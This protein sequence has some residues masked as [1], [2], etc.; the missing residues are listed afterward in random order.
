MKGKLKRTVCIVLALCLILSLAPAVVLADGELR[1][2]YEVN[3]A[4]DL[5]TAINNAISYLNLDGE[6][7]DYAEVWIIGSL[8]LSQPITVGSDSLTI[9][10]GK[11]LRITS[12]GRHCINASVEVNVALFEVN[13]MDGMV[14]F[15]NLEL[16]CENTNG[17][18]IVN[19][20]VALMNMDIR[21]YSGTNHFGVNAAANT[22]DSR[23]FIKNV[24]IQSE[25]AQGA[26]ALVLNVQ[27]HTMNVDIYGGR[28]WRGDDI[29]Y[30]TRID[31]LANSGASIT[32]YGGQFGFDPTDMLDSKSK[33]EH[34][35]D[36]YFVY[37]NDDVVACIGGV[38]YFTN[39]QDAVNAAGTP[40]V[41]FDNKV[42]LWR[43][44]Q[45]AATLTIE[46]KTLELIGN[47][48][49]ITISAADGFDP[50]S[51][52]LICVKGTGYLKLEQISF[53][54]NGVNVG[55]KLQKPQKNDV[56]CFTDI[57]GC[58]FSGF[59][60]AVSN[61]CS[62]MNLCGGSFTNNT[63]DVKLTNTQT[64]NTGFWYNINDIDGLN[65]R[66]VKYKDGGPVRGSVNYC[67]HVMVDID[68][69]FDVEHGEMPVYPGVGSYFVESP[70][71]TYISA[72]IDE[73]QYACNTV[74]EGEVFLTYVSVKSTAAL[75]SAVV[76]FDGENEIVE[77]FSD[78]NRA[79]NSA[80]DGGT[81]RVY[82]NVTTDNCIE[83]QDGKTLT[84][85]GAAEGP[86]QES[87]PSLGTISMIAAAM[88]CCTLPTTAM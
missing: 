15:D 67:S 40:A 1:D 16:Q 74:S 2:K 25:N 59:G 23:L 52:E 4:A 60:I 5:Q 69:A 53:A 75:C 24:K 22:K 84:I 21:N 10:E 46:N 76:A 37:E 47:N 66:L 8:T 62:G 48:D 28:E 32:V 35:D 6:D 68:A 51:E 70:D 27:D 19:C 65:M 43:S 81:V 18:N 38:Y 33:T 36:L 83:I 30:Y 7:H 77:Y 72:L 34:K 44:V 64:D 45:L 41:D 87:L 79:V 11:L 17:I 85:L 86:L 80:A 55:V 39:L 82:R 54:A 26:E 49:S 13:A 73:D 56:D 57:S 14:L 3:N 88:R 12:N 58:S 20:P 78:I 9:P 31:S 71:S 42:Y 29:D 61:D 50:E 63:F